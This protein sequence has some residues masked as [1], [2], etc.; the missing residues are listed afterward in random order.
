MRAYFKYV[1]RLQYQFVYIF[2]MFHV[3]HLDFI[4]DYID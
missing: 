1:L 2:K 3:E 4:D